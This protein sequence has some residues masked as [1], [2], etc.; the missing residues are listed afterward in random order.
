MAMIARNWRAVRL[1]LHHGNDRKEA[2]KLRVADPGEHLGH[3]T[4]LHH[5]IVRLKR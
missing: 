3:C 1:T 5:G 4:K 2:K